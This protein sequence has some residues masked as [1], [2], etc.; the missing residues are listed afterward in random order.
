MRAYLYLYLFALVGLASG[1]A[2]LSAHAVPV[3]R[4]ADTRPAAPQ[5]WEHR[6]RDG[7]SA[8]I[9]GNLL[10]GNVDH[11][12]L[13]SAFSFI[14]NSGPHQLMGHG[15]HFL[16]RNQKIVLIN[17][18]SG[19]LLYAYSITERFN[20]F[21]YSTHMMDE[22]LGLDYRLTNG[23]GLCRHRLLPDLLSLLLVSV[24]IAPEQAWF[25]GDDSRFTV[26]AALRTTAVLDLSEIAELGA[27]AFFM[28]SVTDLADHRLYGEAFLKLR[29][30]ERVWFKIAAADEYDADP[31]PG[32]ERNDLGVFSSLGLDVGG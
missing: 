1:I 23:A 31:P 2:P 30:G 20:A 32:I 10:R 25:I 19:S 14:T 11:A 17:R 12:T 16:T 27:D 28:P 8:E 18:A 5:Q 6:D 13:T 4:S 7:L 26:R 3:G 22:S 29:A 24:A 15:T 9:S 21:V